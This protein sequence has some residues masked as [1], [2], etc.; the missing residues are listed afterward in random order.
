MIFAAGLLYF[1]L[2][3]VADPEALDQAA[4]GKAQA[5]QLPEAE[6]LWKQAIQA[7]PKFFPAHFNLG[8]MFVSQS[9]FADAEPHL[10]QAAQIQPSD[11]NTR[12]LLGMARVNLGRR[13]DGLREWRSA[14]KLQ[15]NH[16]KLLAVMAIEYGKGGYFRE[17]AEVAK[18]ALAL[19]ER[20]LDA[21]LIAIKACQEAQDAEAIELARQAATAFPDSARANFEYGFQLQRAGRNSES[22][23]YFRKAMSLDSKYE[24][25]F[26]FYG[27]ALL[28]VGKY[29]E[30]IRSL[31]AA[32][33]IKPDYVAAAVALARALMEQERYEEAVAGLQNVIRLAPDHPQP[34][35]ML[36]RIYFRLGR[37]E[38]AAREKE[39]SLRLRRADSSL[40]EQ[41]QNRPFPDSPPQ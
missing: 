17:A 6:A 10:A 41:P 28:E 37:E 30:A 39:I 12:Y 35:L 19:S 18:S 16:R 21:Y 32:L 11:F 4:L 34:H 2:S 20:S 33:E 26:Y 13:E 3:Q 27:G 23:P 14:L 8:Y 25:P 36:S 7:S 24:E 5:G 22:L 1:A 31:R 38:D 29:D 9:R 40:M 15:P